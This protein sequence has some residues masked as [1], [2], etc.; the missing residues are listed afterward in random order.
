MRRA[1]RYAVM[2]LILKKLQD[3]ALLIRVNGYIITNTSYK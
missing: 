1:I 3:I 2:Y